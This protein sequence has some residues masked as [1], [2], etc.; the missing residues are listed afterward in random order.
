MS[1]A[2]NG[3]DFDFGPTAKGK[4]KDF[5]FDK[6]DPDFYLDA[7]FDKLSS[8]KMDMSDLDI[9][10][11]PKKPGKSKGRSKET[12]S[13]GERRA[14]RDSFAF[15]FDFEE[16]ADLD[17]ELT[18]TKIDEKSN[19][20]KDKERH[21]NI[22]G[23][24][25]SGDLLAKDVDASE[26]DNISSKHPASLG[27][28]ISKIDAQMDKIKD[29]DPR[30]EDEHLK[31]VLDLKPSNAEEKEMH[32]PISTQEMI[33]CSVEEP[34]QESHPSEKRPFPQPHAQQVAQDLYDHSLVDSVST[35]VTISDVQQEEF[36]TVVR[37]VSL[38]TG[39]E[40][41]S[42]V[43]HVAE[44]VPTRNSSFENSSAHMNSQS[45]KGEMCMDDNLHIGNID[46]DDTRKADSH[47]E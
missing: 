23:S 44:L 8:F 30:N 40:Q 47:L 19:K 38:S 45:Q 5:K 16:F 37:T 29:S 3:M 13:G 39:A 27:A 1:A 22:S 24:G 17:F 35:E 42:N 28:A 18:K 34:V 2:D 9:S 41:N 25:V 7:D 11:P 32:K 6:M 21:S 36:R 10:S 14:K 20:S 26:D 4:K 15:P 46:G 12:S 33:S 31:S 43:R